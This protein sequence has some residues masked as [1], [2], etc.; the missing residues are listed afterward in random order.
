MKERAAFLLVAA[1]LA[2]ASA[3]HAAGPFQFYSITPCRLID[4]RDTSGSYPLTIGPALQHGEVRNLPVWGASARP[5][6]IPAHA[7]GVAVNVVVMSP[8]SQGHLTVFPSGV[9]LP[10]ASTINYNPGEPALANGAS[11]P[12]TDSPTTQLSVFAALA[13]SG[14]TVHL[15]LDVTGYFK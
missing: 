14:N 12:V 13:G 10:L 1:S 11:I 2:G 8:T 6:G 4:T 3:L 7:L 9:S 15:I 5:C